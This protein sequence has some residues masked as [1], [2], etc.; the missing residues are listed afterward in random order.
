MVSLSK[1]SMQYLTINPNTAPEP[2]RDR[3]SNHPKA[4][5]IPAAK[6]TAV[7]PKLSGGENASI[8]FVGT[9]TTI[10]YPP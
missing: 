2:T 1:E 10:L 3:P 9:A 8:Y 4:E 5:N 6:S 7:H